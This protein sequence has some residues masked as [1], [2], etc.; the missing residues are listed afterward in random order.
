MQKLPDNSIDSIVTDPPYGLGEIKDLP[1]LLNAWMNNEDDSHAVGKNGFM[2]KEW[3]KSVPSPK[4]WKECIRV[5]KPGGHLLVFAGTRTQDLMGISIRLAG[6]ELRDEIAYFGNLHWVY[7]S[8]FPKSHN[9]SKAIDKRGGENLSWF[10]DYILQI[11][12]EKNISKKELTMLFPSKNGKPTGWL[13]NKKHSQGITLEQYNTIKDFLQLPFENISELKR[14]VIGKKT[15]GLGS[16]KTYAFTENNDK[17]AKEIDITAPASDQAKKWD[18]WGT[19]LKPAHE[20]ILMFRKPLAE[21]TVADNVMKYGT[22]GI[23]IDGCRVSVD[24]EVDKSQLRTLNRSQRECDNN[25]QKWGMNKS[26][27]DTPQVVR[28]DGRFPANVIH[29][30]SEEV[31]ECFP[32]SKGQCGDLKN[33]KKDRQSPN[34][35]YG[36]MS[37]SNDCFKRNDKGSASRFFYCAKVSKMERNEGC[38]KNNHPT[39]K[40]VEL[41]K[42]LVRLVTPPKGR[43]LDPFMGS[44]STGKA[45]VVEGFYFMGIEQ[46]TDYFNIAKARIEYGKKGSEASKS[47]WIQ[48]E[49]F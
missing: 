13:W 11:A 42:Y 5:L 9:I 44:G 2:G 15:A 3:D 32:D 16:G 47:E 18:G 24:K 36:K 17:S 21:K 20:P 7:G 29:D 41:M 28:E 38:E 27:S 40:P 43:V 34:G 26:D 4:V 8:G 33:H 46:D 31:E 30:G 48:G 35:I 39:I 22:G 37:S 12:Q 23:N 10:I 19:A 49:L 45:C 25:N 14:T 1:S 6:F